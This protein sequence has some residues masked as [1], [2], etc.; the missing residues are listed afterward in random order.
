LRSL[1]KAAPLLLNV[2]FLMCFFW[3]IFV[4]IGV[5]S[6]KS[7]LRRQ[8]TWIDPADSNNNWTNTF[9]FCGG[10]LDTETHN[11]KPWLKADG[12]PGATSHKGFLC[13]EQSVCQE[14]QNPY[15]GTVSYDNIF[16]SFQLVFVLM[17]T[18]TFTDLMYYLTNSD[19]LAAALFSAVGVVILYFWLVNLLIAVITS[20]FQV[21]REGSKSSPFTGEADTRDIEEEVDPNPQIKRRRKRFKSLFKKTKWFWIAVILMGLVCMCLTSATMG[22][23]R[24][25]FINIAEKVVTFLLLLEIGLRALV[26]VIDGR[27]FFRSKANIVDLVIVIATCVMQIPVIHDSGTV[28]AWLT[29][30]QI[31][32]IYRVVLA[33]SLTR[34]LILTVLGNFTG[35]LN[36]M[37]FVG[38]INFLAAILAT[39]LFRG[40]LP[41]VDSNQGTIRVQFFSLWN[42]F[43]GMYQIFSSENWTTIMYDLTNYNDYYNT[44]WVAATFTIIWFILA[45]FITLN[46]FIAII[47]ENF[48]I[49]EDKKRLKQIENYIEQK[50]LGLTSGHGNISLANMI[51]QGLSGAPARR[52]V[53]GHSNAATDLLLKEAIIDEFL[54]QKED[55]DDVPGVIHPGK[56]MGMDDLPIRPIRPAPG[57]VRSGTL[58]SIWTTFVGK[59]QTNE[60]NPFYTRI[61]ISRLNDEDAASSANPNSN[62]D[63]INRTRDLIKQQRDRE[64]SQREFLRKHPNYNVSMYMFTPHNRFRRW[65]QMIVGPGR[66]GDRVEGVQPFGYAHW[67]FSAFIYACVVAMVL[68]ACITTPLYQKQHFENFGD[69][70]RTLMNWLTFSD[71]GFGVVFTIEA[72]IKVI[73]D[74][75]FWTPHAYYRSTWGFIDG[76]VLATL[77]IS[78]IGSFSNDADVSRSVGA[79]KALRALRLLNISDRARDN[80]HAV[81]VRGAPKILGAAFVSMGLLVPFAIYGLNLFSDKMIACN[82]GGSNI[83]N[84]N[85]C[86]GEYATSTPFNWNVYAPRVAANSYFSFDNFGASL[87]ILFQ[88]VSQEGWIDVMFSAQSI[89]GRFRQPIPFASQGNPIFF[90]AFNLL[91]S[92]FVLTL[93]VSVFMR[94]YTEMTG[95]AFLTT[96]QRSWLE[97]RK[98]LYQINPSKRSPNLDRQSKW[99]RRIYRMA[100]TKSGKNGRWY[101]FVTAVLILH[102]IMLCTEFDPSPKW[103]DDTRDGL[104]LLFTVVFGVNIIIRLIGLGWPRFRKSSWDIYSLGAVSGTA[105]ST[106]LVL[107]FQNDNIAAMRIQ[108]LFLVSIA[109]LLIPRNNQLDQLFKTAATSLPLITNLM[110]TWFVLF[111][112]FA[113]AMTQAFSLTRFGP[114]GSG[115]A[116]LRDVPKAMILLFRMSVGEGWNQVMEDYATAVEPLCNGGSGDALM[117]DCGSPSWAR[118][119][120]IAWNILSMYLFVNLFISLIYESF[121]Y[122]YQ[123]SSGLSIITREEIRRFK[124]AWAVV[125]PEGTGFIPK[126]PASLARVLRELGGVF[127]MR[128]YPAEFGVTRL[129]EECALQPIRPGST[130]TLNNL[131]DPSFNRPWSL[132]SYEPYIHRSKP[133]NIDI[134][135]LNTRLAGLPIYEIRFRRNRLNLFWEEIMS[136]ADRE[137]GIGFTDLLLALTHYKVINDNKSLQLPEWLRRKQRLV[138][139]EQEVR[140]KICL[141][142]FEASQHRKRFKTHQERV[143][144]AR[145]ATVGG[146]KFEFAVPEIFV[147]DEDVLRR[148]QELRERE[149]RAEEERRRMQNRGIGEDNPFSDTSGGVTG[150]N[151]PS[152]PSMPSSPR[153]ELALSR[154]G[155]LQVSPLASPITRP[156]R[157]TPP[158]LTPQFLPTITTTDLGDGPSSSHR[159]NPSI[160]SMT[161][162]PLADY[163]WRPSFEGQVPPLNLDAPTEDGRDG[164]RSRANSAVSVRDMLDQLEQSAWGESLRRSMSQSRS[165]SRNRGQSSRPDGTG[166]ARQGSGDD[167]D[168]GRQF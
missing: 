19:Y 91:A 135:A 23:A 15:N 107:A 136:K 98:R 118:V 83:D 35:L 125:D 13:P 73:A 121:S 108:R 53:P 137:K 84:L 128:I 71:V 117:S 16:Q 79:L 146:Q 156:A 50:E 102:L 130:V 131:D 14:S 138:L 32:R 27:N 72:I 114:S 74:G 42:S 155:S 110:A 104:F 60:P 28:Y 161:Q 86:W 120:F 124:E 92:V 152:A 119:L 143:R 49:S 145:I 63:A 40:A 67:T 144:A 129:T 142:F 149:R 139:I 46:M 100:V 167:R 68:I 70:K 113:I 75:F 65:C 11:P 116:N 6:F 59:F 7:S 44:A 81:I 132:Q 105:I 61:N 88:I 77:W 76:I 38:L 66:G 154:R 22:P 24:A 97:L 164:Q 134:A 80:F 147:E 62:T 43:L 56:T 36:L 158:H 93:F 96:D 166:P 10:Y 33:V 55:G 54:H 69:E 47:Q 51:R 21:I 85:D 37:V 159:H 127:D 3:L 94:N 82:D 31:I 48:D 111:L 150:V 1:K 25:E 168:R 18:N 163:G 45:N 165:R 4:I 126:N 109:F 87:S 30:F 141:R 99:K 148:E 106:I 122:V 112:I 95:V 12:T 17:T 162:S 151:T 153:S 26:D 78:V 39:Q 160:G 9:Q 90:V 20:T 5:Q 123:V 103:W 64:K 57:L 2:G 115:N 101:R 34:D 52:A 8:C 41:A 140:R 58:S 29:F 157:L 133:T 89:T